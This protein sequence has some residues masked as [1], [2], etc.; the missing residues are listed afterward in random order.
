MKDNIE[1][2]KNCDTAY[3]LLMNPIKMMPD[4]MA[5][6][7]DFYA[8]EQATAV[9]D[10][11]NIGEKLASWT[12]AAEECLVNSV[13]VALTTSPPTRATVKSKAG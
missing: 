9:E 13:D 3:D 12:E 8:G 2:G 10:A 11:S 1:C 6:F 7:N 4:S 5:D